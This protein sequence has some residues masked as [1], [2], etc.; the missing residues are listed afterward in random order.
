MQYTST[1]VIG[2]F[3]FCLTILLSSCSPAQAT[4][5]A[6]VTWQVEVAH[7]DIKESL[8]AIEVVTQY[9]GTKMDVE[10][11]QA[12]NPGSSYLI[13]KVTLRK[14]GSQAVPFDWKQLVV[15]DKAGTP[16]ARHANDTFLEQYNYSPRLT[17]LEIRFGENA[18]WLCFE[19]PAAAAAGPLTLAYQASGSQQKI[20]LQK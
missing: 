13:L 8:Q 12:P 14:T 9:D 10:H 3:A 5:Q 20:A 7:V 4:P 18:G 16:Y 2:F 15:L 1:R 11:K 6:D 19:I 17:G